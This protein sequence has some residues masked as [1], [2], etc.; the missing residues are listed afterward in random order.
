MSR[1]SFTHRNGHVA[2]LFHPKTQLISAFYLRSCKVFFL[3]CFLKFATFFDCSTK[4]PLYCPPSTE[5]R[6][7][8]GRKTSGALANFS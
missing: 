5:D 2:Q 8:H 1:T 3:P 7:W 4:V 6:Q